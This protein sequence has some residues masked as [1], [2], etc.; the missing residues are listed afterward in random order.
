MGSW[1]SKVRKSSNKS[2]NPSSRSDKEECGEV[3]HN[4]TVNH[5]NHDR[6]LTS[7]DSTTPERQ[8]TH[9]KTQLNQLACRGKKQ[10]SIPFLHPFEILTD[11][12]LNYAVFALLTYRP[13]LQLF[14]MVM[15]WSP[16]HALPVKTAQI[17][18]RYKILF[19]MSSI[20]STAI[21]IPTL[22]MPSLFY[23]HA[24]VFSQKPKLTSTQ[25]GE[26]Q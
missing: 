23:W 18:Q 5:Q 8:T 22:L 13:Y 1:P 19:R 6:H 9:P 15:D 17:N 21:Y 25:R 26:W 24:V 20:E 11:D 14:N 12:S 2:V 10:C 4:G 3:N 16:V 7:Q